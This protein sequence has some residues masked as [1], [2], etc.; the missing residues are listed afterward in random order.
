MS[1]ITFT[2]LQS[3]LLHLLADG[4][5]H[6]GNALGLALGISRTAIWKN[7]AQLIS[8][9]APIERHPQQGY[10]L[11][12]P[13]ILLN[14][15]QIHAELKAI[16]PACHIEP[17]V[18]LFASI[19]ST[20]QYLKQT[21][22][23][24]KALDICCAE[25]Q[26]AGRGRLSRHWHSPFGENIYCSMRFHING[27]FSALSG[28]S[29]VVGIAIVE[30]LR[31]LGIHDLYVKWPNDIVWRDKKLC[32]ILIDLIAE[33]Y[34]STDSIIGI[35][36]NVNSPTQSISLPQEDKRPWCS[37][38][39]ITGQRHDRNKII[40]HLVVALH[41]HLDTFQAYGFQAFQ[42]AWCKIDYLYGKAVEVI[43]N[44]GPLVGNA[45]GVNS[46]G[47]LLVKDETGQTH[48]VSSGD[49]SLM[50]C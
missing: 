30:A 42:S 18:H 22:R 11:S 34:G 1:T 24:S 23:K 3:Q 28:L 29:L 37:L 25:T 5:R 27:D 36:L 7:I 45:C 43:Q 48:D 26:T 10:N 46:S 17:N 35:G 14:K 21:L 15:Q 20:N 31:V 33:S 2:N 50:K 19:D 49:A 32:G 41:N 13:M 9:G 6:S 4:H 16:S 44:C 39:E 8:F 47:Q 40:A 38:Y 12:C